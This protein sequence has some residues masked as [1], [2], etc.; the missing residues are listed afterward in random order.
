MSRQVIIILTLIFF[1][2]PVTQARPNSDNHAGIPT[3]VITKLDI[4][5]K[6][7]KLTYK[8]RNKTKNDLWIFEG[9]GKYD[10]SAE[11]FMEGNKQTLLIRSRLDIPSEPK[12]GTI[13]SFDGRYIHLA[14][15]RSLSESI[16]LP[17]PVQRCYG[18]PGR[19]QKPGLQ[20]A[21]QLAFEIGY[22]VGDLREIIRNRLEK[23]NMTKGKK[24]PVSPA[25]P[26]KLIEWFAG[27]GVL[28]FNEM[29]EGL[30]SRDEE[31][32]IPYTDQLLKG[33]QLVRIAI[34][35]LRIPYEEREK[36]TTSYEPPD[37]T[38]CTK[39]HISYQPSLLEYFFPYDSQQRLL[40]T[41]EI[42]YLRTVGN[43]VLEDKKDIEAFISIIEN[44]IPTGYEVIWKR[45]VAHVTCS[46]GSEYSISFPIYNNMASLVDSKMNVF[47]P[48]EDFQSLK[49]IPPLMR[50]IYLRVQC[51]SNLK[52]LWHRFQLYHEAE[53]N[54]TKN[55][56]TD[57]EIIYPHPAKWCDVMVPAY[58]S[59]GMLDYRIMNAYKCPSGSEDKCHYA[60]NPNCKPDSP[61]DMVLLFET[62]AGWNQHGGPELFTFD[63]HDPK[64]GCVLL[65]DGTV[66]FIRT[67][68][69]LRRLRW[70]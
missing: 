67:K 30:R 47:I 7:L 3:I 23:E 28:T 52:N 6:K 24:S 13:P 11:V 53:K 57:K 22:Y 33:E 4:I 49:G 8:I 45:T 26:N 18:F 62:K 38:S 10:I 41:E 19:P 36:K 50:P 20:Y 15:G 34:D 9:V 54:R 48:A 69:E 21:T 29:S 63:N 16:T 55:S 65:N 40:S 58:K 35:G 25:T 56:S 60:M 61:S 31:V 42:S 1:L 43:I 59:I 66:K 5:E 17:I 68:E 14:P 70:K 51:A 12:R 2:P 44:R 39:I 27:L 64:G 37:L 46:K 32:L